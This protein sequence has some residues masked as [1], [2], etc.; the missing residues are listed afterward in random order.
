MASVS[1]SPVIE[2]MRV[3]KNQEGS[4]VPMINKKLDQK[5]II[6]FFKLDCSFSRVIGFNFAR[7]REIA[8]TIGYCGASKLTDNSSTIVFFAN[9]RA[10]LTKLEVAVLSILDTPPSIGEYG[11]CKYGT[12]CHSRECRLIHIKPPPPP[13]LPPLPPPPPSQRTYDEGTSIYI[14][15]LKLCAPQNKVAQ[16]RFDATSKR[17]VIVDLWNIHNPPEIMSSFDLSV[18][19]LSAL[20]AP[21]LQTSIGGSPLRYVGGGTSA[22]GEPPIISSEWLRE[23][24]NVQVISRNPSDKEVLVDVMLH[25]VGM[26]VIFDHI[27]DP[28][29]NT[30]VIAT[31]DGATDNITSFPQLAFN[32]AYHG[33][34]VEIWGWRH[35]MSKNFKEVASFFKDNRISLHYLDDHAGKIMIPKRS[36][37]ERLADVAIHG[38]C[39]MSTAADKIPVFSDGKHRIHDD[40]DDSDDRDDRDDRDRRRR[41]RS[42]SRSRDKHRSRDH[43]S[44]DH[45]S[46]DHRSR[47]H[48]S[49]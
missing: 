36:F 45:R 38:L 34:G 24:Y 32:A 30:L 2:A 10:T 49:R 11:V 4:L 1:L 17:H 3:P 37:L 9:D 19:G 33:I 5:N 25:A 46:R 6:S 18:S 12:R 16:W 31:G 26:K 48:R 44:R 40:R 13:S 29:G 8:S 42:R 39:V 7:I 27:V 23:G 43:R 41:S 35:S 20:L 22:S 28:T 47:D 14:K 21:R 15:S